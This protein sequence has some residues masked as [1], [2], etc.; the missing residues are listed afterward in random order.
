M[1]LVQTG[2][3]VG[4]V[5]D[6]VERLSVAAESVDESPCSPVLIVVGDDELPGNDQQ[7]ASSAIRLPGRAH[8]EGCLGRPLRY[9]RTRPLPERE[10]E[11][12]GQLVRPFVAKAG[13]DA[14]KQA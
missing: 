13:L 1:E 6:V 9:E 7:R 3:E 12:E 2:V 11:L 14:V 4:D 5:L 8:R 10:R